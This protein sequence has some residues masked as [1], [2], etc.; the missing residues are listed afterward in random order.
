MYFMMGGSTVKPLREKAQQ[1][2]TT[3]YPAPLE[4]LLASSSAHTE[5]LL[6]FIWMPC[7]LLISGSQPS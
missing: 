1:Q 5:F 2:K 4:V 3:P 7:F 6:T